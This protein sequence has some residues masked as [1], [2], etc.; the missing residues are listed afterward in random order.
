[1]RKIEKFT[2]SLLADMRYEFGYDPKDSRK[3]AWQ[4]RHINRLLTKRREQHPVPHAGGSLVENARSGGSRLKH[5]ADWTRADKIAAAGLLV[6]LLAL[7]ATWLAVPSISD[8][9]AKKLARPQAPTI[10]TS[11][12]GPS[13]PQPPPKKEPVIGT[14]YDETDEAGQPFSIAKSFEKNEYY[15]RPGKARGRDM[16]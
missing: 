2:N 3:S 12:Q 9:I 14:V 11:Q 16:K 8:V 5:F 1:M 15:T 7:P 10:D 6:T 13:H 4:T